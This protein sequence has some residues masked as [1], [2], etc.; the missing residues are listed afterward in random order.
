[1]IIQ[2]SKSIEL[3]IK[4]CNILKANLNIFYKLSDKGKV[5]YV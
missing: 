5:E 3:T 4:L 1:M 2:E